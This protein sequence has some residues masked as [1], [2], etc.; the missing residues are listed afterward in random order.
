MP[1][2][3]YKLILLP[4]GILLGGGI[5]VLG[6][7]AD[8]GGYFRVLRT[9]VARLLN[10]D[11]GANREPAPPA[12]AAALLPAQTLLRA[13]ATATSELVDTV[14]A[15]AKVATAIRAGLSVDPGE[16][17][18]LERLADL[19][20]LEQEIARRAGPAADSALR[21]AE[22]WSSA[23]IDESLVK[24][25]RIRADMPRLL[26]DLARLRAPFTTPQPAHVASASAEAQLLQA[27]SDLAAERLARHWA[28]HNAALE[29]AARPQTGRVDAPL[30]PAL[31]P[32]NQ[33]PASSAKPSPDQPH[34]PPQVAPPRSVSAPLH[35]AVSGGTT[36]PPATPAPAAPIRALR[37]ELEPVDGGRAARVRIRNTGTAPL[38]GMVARITIGDA[39]SWDASVSYKE[40]RPDCSLQWS[41]QDRVLTWA[42]ES[43]VAS[44]SEWVAHLPINPADA[45]AFWRVDIE[46]TTSGLRERNSFRVDRPSIGWERDAGH[47]LSKGR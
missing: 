7:E 28:E 3:I 31:P 17:V 42:T 16:A 4:V 46:A 10:V 22:R 38:A 19:G 1:R 43:I 41:R 29:R 2:L 44:G 25:A 12:V 9:N 33:R 18:M 34:A 35:P 15:G 24:A 6:Y 8:P 47:T 40:T 27:R 39:T 45:A 5:C 26:A 11:L 37:I 20:R 21:L 13:T 14:L 32:V 23:G 30:P 36:G